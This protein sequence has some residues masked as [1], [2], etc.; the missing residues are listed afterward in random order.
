MLGM[1]LFFLR[2]FLDLAFLL[3]AS[4]SH[5]WCLDS[6]ISLGHKANH[7]GSVLSSLFYQ[8]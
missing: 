5:I 3:E 2:L 4:K 6:L 1:A 7:I 8:D